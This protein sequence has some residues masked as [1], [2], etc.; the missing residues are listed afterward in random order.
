MKP[1]L[2]FEFLHTFAEV[3]LFAA[4]MSLEACIHLPFVDMLLSMYLGQGSLG[5]PR[6]YIYIYICRTG[7]YGLSFFSKTGPVR[8]PHVCHTINRHF[9]GQLWR[10]RNRPK[11]RELLT[12]WGKSS[13][14]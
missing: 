2:R 7:G 9:G 8:G 1:H 12:S 4:G 5:H 10:Q 3:Y 6:G 13:V 11:S 14:L